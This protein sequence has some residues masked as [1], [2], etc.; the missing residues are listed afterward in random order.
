[1]GKSNLS[2]SDVERMKAEKNIEGLVKALMFEGDL[3]PKRRSAGTGR[4]RR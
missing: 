2:K 1:M 3:D 4:N